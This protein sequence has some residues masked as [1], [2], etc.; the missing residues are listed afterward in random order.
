M[1]VKYLPEP[2]PCQWS[3]VASTVSAQA[4]ARIGVVTDPSQTQIHLAQALPGHTSFGLCQKAE[5]A[6][7]LPCLSRR[8]GSPRLSFDLRPPYGYLPFVVLPQTCQA[9]CLHSSTASAAKIQSSTAPDAPAR[10][11]FARAFD[12]CLSP[13]HSRSSPRDRGEP[14]PHLASVP[15][16]SASR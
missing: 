7:A 11:L 13:R 5:R 6:C 1:R 8:W 10:S 15:L 9:R 3:W 16:Q 14:Y 2:W 4:R 12:H